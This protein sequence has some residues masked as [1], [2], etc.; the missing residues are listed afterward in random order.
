MLKL[1]LA[2]ALLW[3]AVHLLVS[4]PARRILCP[5]RS[6]VV[7]G[8]VGAAGSRCAQQSLG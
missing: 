1:V 7:R 6:R 5:V 8:C 4:K 2:Y 3:L